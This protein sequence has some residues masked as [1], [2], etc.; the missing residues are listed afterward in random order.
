MQKEEKDMIL[1]NSSKH[2]LEERDR[3]ISS[4]PVKYV[5]KEH[6]LKRKSNNPYMRG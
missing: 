5:A 4:G 3:L 6:W 1:F 2:F